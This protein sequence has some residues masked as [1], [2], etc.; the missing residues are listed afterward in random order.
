MATTIF[1][2]K[3][4][5]WLL[6]FLSPLK[7]LVVLLVGKNNILL[8]FSWLIL[9]FCSLPM[10]V[11]FVALTDCL[12]CCSVQI[13]CVRLNLSLWDIHKVYNILALNVKYNNIFYRSGSYYF[14]YISFK[15][16][17]IKW[18]IFEEKNIF[19]IKF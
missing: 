19:N 15:S 5:I 16:K 14:A 8:K 3:F 9:Y 13:R 12:H 17:R 6:L 4:R 1:N 10:V 11:I 18:N 7:Y 2:L